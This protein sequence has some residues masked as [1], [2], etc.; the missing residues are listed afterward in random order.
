MAFAS[1]LVV[2]LHCKMLSSGNSTRTTISHD[3]ISEKE[4]FRSIKELQIYYLLQCSDKLECGQATH[5]NMKMDQ[6]EKRTLPFLSS[7]KF[8]K[9]IL[10]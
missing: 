10:Y 5:K 2:Q 4:Y 6:E 3:N 9:Y 7:V 1:I 8:S